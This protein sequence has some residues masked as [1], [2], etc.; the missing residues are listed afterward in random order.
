M[1]WKLEE[2]QKISGLD[3]FDAIDS[4][5]KLKKTEYDR[6]VNEDLRWKTAD[7]IVELFKAKAQM[8]QGLAAL[9]TAGGEAER[10][11]ALRMVSK[12]RKNAAV[13]PPLP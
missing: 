8:Q 5:I 2:D 11:A 1:A 9:L 10:E 7:S 13:P 12:I 3:D 4:M 6:G